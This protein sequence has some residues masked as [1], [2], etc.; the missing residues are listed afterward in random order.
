ML[1]TGVFWGTWF[2]LTRSLHDFDPAEFIHIGKV[3]ISNVAMPMRVLMPLCI[4]GML[5]TLWFYP[6]KKSKRFFIGV[7]AFILIII[8]LLITLLILVPIDNEIKTWTVLTVPGDF[9]EI[10]NRWQYYHAMRTFTSITSFICF[11]LAI[12]VKP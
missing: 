3:I 7:A 11:T 4:L 2:T 1:V 12:E 8:T 9:E 10:R 6:N 5:L